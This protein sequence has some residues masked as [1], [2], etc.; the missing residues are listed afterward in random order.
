LEAIASE[1]IKLVKLLLDPSLYNVKASIDFEVDE[2][3]A[4]SRAVFYQRADFVKLLL[5]AGADPNKR[6]VPKLSLITTAAIQGDKATVNLL[7]KA[8]AS[9]NNTDRNLMMRRNRKRN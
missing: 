4:L 5:E 9:L 7:M 1:D 8:G 3:T 6:V 2:E